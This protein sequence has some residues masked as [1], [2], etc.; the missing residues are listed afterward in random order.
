[1]ALRWQDEGAPRLHLV[2]LDGAREGHPVND[3]VIVRIADAVRIPCEVGG[4]VRLFETIKRYLE[5]G[6]KRV[7]LGTAAVE[8]ETLL[9]QACDA[10]PGSIA[11]AVDARDGQ[12]VVRGW[13]R[14][15][16]ENAEE[17]MGRLAGLGVPRF[18]Y[19]DIARDGTLLGPNFVAIQRAVGVVSVPVVASGGISTADQVRR[20]SETGVEGAVLGR[21]LYEGALTLSDALRAAR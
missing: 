21:A 5:S 18:V 17:L 20:L 15:S 6:L 11:V 3:D 2:D 7:V 14:Q 19:T 9:A 1:M 13:L 4:G 16:G 12:I 8:D 10:L